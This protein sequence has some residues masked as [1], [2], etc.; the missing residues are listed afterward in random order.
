MAGKEHSGKKY[1]RGITGVDGRVAVIDIYSF[2]AAY[3]ITCPARQH[4]L[5][6]IAMAGLRGKGDQLQDLYEARDAITRAIQMQEQEMGIGDVPSKTYTSDENGVHDI[7]Q[8][9]KWIV[10]PIH[11]GYLVIYSRSLPFTSNIAK[12]FGMSEE[13]AA[14]SFAA[15]LNRR[16]ILPTD[17]M[18]KV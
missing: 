4:A 12:K 18:F 2:L 9:P 17:S 1:H 5:K 6:K 3:E 13:Q 8:N 14:V 16:G 15:D 10:Q 7:Q 11:G